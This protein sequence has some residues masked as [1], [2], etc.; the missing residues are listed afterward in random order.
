MAIRRAKREPVGLGLY[1]AR[2]KDTIEKP[3]AFKEEEEEE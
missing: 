2:R 3:G 1:R